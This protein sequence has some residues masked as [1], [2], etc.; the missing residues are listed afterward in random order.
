VA[1]QFAREGWRVRVVEP[2]PMAARVATELL[3]FHATEVRLTIADA[4]RFCRTT[5][6]RY[7]A[8]IFDAFDRGSIPPHLIT[9]ECLASV[10]DRVAPNGV[11]ALA[12]VTRGWND[13]VIVSLAAMLGERFHSVFALPTSEPPNALGSIVLLASNGSLDLPDERLPQPTDFLM[14]PDEH[15][16]VVQ[17]NHAWFNRFAPLTRGAV[18]L[19][20]DRNPIDVWSDP[21]QHAARVDLHRSFATPPKSW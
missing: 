5:S 21:V 1:K 12:I 19:T 2:D 20:D 4:R 3:S 10:A 9:R 14:N 7:A 6:G 16:A 13:P 11:L 15:W 8:V 18:I 17:M